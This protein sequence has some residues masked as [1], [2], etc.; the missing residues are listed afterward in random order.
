MAE[1]I[2]D[3]FE[4]YNRPATRFVA[5]FVGTLSH[6]RAR[7]SIDA[8]AG[9]VTV[10]GQQLRLGRAL[11]GARTGRYCRWRCG[12]RRWRRRSG[13]RRGRAARAGC[14]DVSFLGSVVR[15][16]MALAPQVLSFDTFNTAAARPPAAGEAVEVRFAPGDV[17]VMEDAPA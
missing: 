2:G 1:Q 11:D 3:P 13:G 5:S 10:D 9:V 14:A 15:V 8:G 6:A 7:W 16:R 17:L 4:I 12:R